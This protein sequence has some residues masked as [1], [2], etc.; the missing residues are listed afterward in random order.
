M[1]RSGYC[2]S[3]A[4]NIMNAKTLFFSFII[5]LVT[6][7]LM[8]GLAIV[9]NHYL[10]MGEASGR[11][12]LSAMFSSSPQEPIE[13][14]EIKDILITLKSDNQAE[15]Y[16]LLELNLVTNG[17]EDTQQVQDILPVVRGA[18]VSLLYDQDYDEVRAISVNE[19][20]NMLMEA[21]AVRFRNMNMNIPFRDIIISKMIFQ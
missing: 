21:C 13:F 17:P 6:A 15:R 20:H 10:F 5:A 4:K 7:M 19:L 8:A 3:K 12:F 11:P 2:R 14:V 9:G 16:L 18:T 1:K